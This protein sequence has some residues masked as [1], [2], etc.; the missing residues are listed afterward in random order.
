MLVEILSLSYPS[1]RK[2]SREVKPT[3]WDRKFLPDCY[4]LTV[5]NS[6]L[7][8]SHGRPSQQSPSPF[9]SCDLELL[10]MIFTF[11]I[12]LESIKMNRHA[13]I[14]VKRLFVQKL[15]P[16]FTDTHTHTTHRTNCSTW[17]TKMVGEECELHRITN[18][19]VDR[20]NW[21]LI[22]CLQ[23]DVALLTHDFMKIRHCLTKLWNVYR[24]LLFYWTRCITHVA[25]ERVNSHRR[26][27]VMLSFNVP[28]I[29]SHQ[30]RG[31]KAVN[32]DRA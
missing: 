7:L 3:T 19:N 28:P 16:G 21:N 8:F 14:L 20:L 9:S 11:E 29:S 26:Q 12:D 17:I 25:H 10:P 5:S 13:N 1:S 24:G 22:I 18:A 27:H 31:D 6:G 15:L 2:P 32:K 23:L 4:L 30:A